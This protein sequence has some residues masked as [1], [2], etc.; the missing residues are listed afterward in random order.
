MSGFSQETTTILYTVMPMKVN[1]KPSNNVSVMIGVLHV[2]F[3]EEQP[4][5]K[6]KIKTLWEHAFPYGTDVCDTKEEALFKVKER[7]LT[8]S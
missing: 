2:A 1:N 6:Y 5:G 4:D 8:K 7:L 3:I